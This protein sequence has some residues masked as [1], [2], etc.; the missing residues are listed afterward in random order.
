MGHGK[1]QEFVAGTD[2]FSEHSYFSVDI[3]ITTNGPAIAID[4]L[5]NRLYRVDYCDDLER[6][7]WETLADNLPGTGH[8]LLIFDPDNMRGRCYRGF[9][10][11]AE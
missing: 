4:S 9:V 1:R 10:E 11:M 7:H 3:A 8:T 5:L 6:G 2:P